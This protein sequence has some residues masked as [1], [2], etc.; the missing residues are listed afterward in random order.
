MTK[1]LRLPIQVLLSAPTIFTD[2]AEVSSGKLPNLLPN[3]RGKEHA[4]HLRLSRG[5]FRDARN[6]KLWNVVACSL[7]RWIWCSQ[8]IASTRRVSGVY[9]QASIGTIRVDDARSFRAGDPTGA[10]GGCRD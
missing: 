8:L 9:R 6:G 10:R 5:L 7:S 4:R 2:S 3:P 1:T